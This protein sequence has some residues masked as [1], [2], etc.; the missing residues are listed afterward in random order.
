MFGAAQRLDGILD[1]ARIDTHRADRHLL[2]CPIEPEAAQHIGPDGLPGFGAQS[3][4]ASGRIVAGQSGQVDTGNGPQQPGS[5][6]V[7]LDGPALG[8]RFDA[9]LHRA[10]VDMRAHHPIQ[11]QRSAGVPSMSGLGRFL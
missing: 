1:P 5:L 11:I 6:P 3:L 10:A 7:L 4:D 8:Q 2:A 9:P